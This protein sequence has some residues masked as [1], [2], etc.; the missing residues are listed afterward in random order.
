[1]A[2]EAF[3]RVYSLTI[4]RNNSLI[5]KTIPQLLVR[6]A[7]GV[8]QL[9]ADPSY[10]DF[11][12]KPNGAL[13]INEPR[14][15]ADISYTKEGNTN[16]QGTVIQIY[17]LLKD[18]QKF[19]S[20]ED[21]VLLRAGYRSIDGDS[22]P[23][24]FSGQVISVETVKS[25]QDTITKLVCSAIDLPRKNIRFSKSPIR[26][27]TNEDVCN[28]FA[29]VAANAGI[30][31]GRVFVQDKV[32]YPSGI[33]LNGSLWPVMEKFCSNF[34]LLNYVTLGRLY[35]EPAA[36]T[37]PVVAKVVVSAEN[38]KNTI[39]SEDDA[40]GKSS[41]DETKKSGIVFNTFLNGDITSAKIVNI[42]FG[43]YRGDYI[44]SSISHKLDLEGKDWDTIVSC[45]RRN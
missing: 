33:A 45:K 21:T 18:N 17:N 39:R 34:N 10:T 25:G 22:P 20:S 2:D 29:K 35:I 9:L 7:I 41:S 27:E 24:I 26:N 8:P 44:I 31:T 36:E 42:D 32:T 38:I 28:Y 23:L 6:P 40:S 4:G 13:V 5:E 14:I 3:D 16:K 1:M 43:E 12:A 19:I 11:N 37:A 15:T 30:P